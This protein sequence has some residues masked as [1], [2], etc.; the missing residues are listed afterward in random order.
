M[1][2][3]DNLQD[4]KIDKINKS[5]EWKLI[6]SVVG[7][8]NSITLPNEGY[9]EFL[10]LMGTPTF[11]WSEHIT[12]HDLNTYQVF[13]HSIGDS[14]SSTNVTQFIYVTLRGANTIYIDV[15]KQNGEDTGNI[16]TL[17]VYGR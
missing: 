13:T 12:K 11:R 10:I 7:K 9:E 15:A 3:L 6:G 8:G 14:S 1:A 4:E 17:V 2:V 16:A 5:L